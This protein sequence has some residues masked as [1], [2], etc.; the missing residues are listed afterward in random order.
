[1][2]NFKQNLLKKRYNAE[3]RFQ[4]YGKIAIGLAL[5]FLAVFMFQIFS[6]GYS[7]FQK[8]WIV[9]EVHYDK[10]LLL[11]D[12]ETVS[13]THLTLPTSDLV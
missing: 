3:R 13:Y 12:A 11:I 6:K 2:N 7:A 10:E 9:T 8:T 1:M 5:S 4:W